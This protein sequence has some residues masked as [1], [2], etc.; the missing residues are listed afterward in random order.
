M[1]HK[2]P[3]SLFICYAKSHYTERG[4]ALC[5]GAIYWYF[6]FKFWRENMTNSP[7]LFIYSA[8]KI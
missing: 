5:H 1:L 2:Y 4:Y 6:L 3:D 8:A 7:Q